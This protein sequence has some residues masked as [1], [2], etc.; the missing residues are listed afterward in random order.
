MDLEEVVRFRVKAIKF[1]ATPTATERASTT[2]DRPAI[3]SKENPYVP[4]QVIGDINGDGLGCISWWSGEG[5]I[6]K[7]D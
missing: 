2:G 7:D 3:G 1:H 4:M 5:D 6:D